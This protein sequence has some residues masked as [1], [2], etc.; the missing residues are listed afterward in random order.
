MNIDLTHQYLKLII[1]IKEFL[2]ADIKEDYLIKQI[3]NNQLKD[4]KILFKFF[5]I[6]KPMLIVEIFHNDLIC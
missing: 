5:E 2:N 4:K 6:L 3:I 1:P